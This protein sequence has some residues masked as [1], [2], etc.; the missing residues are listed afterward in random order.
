MNSLSKN[1]SAPGLKVGWLVASAEFVSAF[2][3]Y[4]ST[5]YGGPAS[6]FYTLVEVLGRMERWLL[7]GAQSLDRSHVAEFEKSYGLEL[8]TLQ[9][10]F[11]H[12]ALQREARTADLCDT[13]DAS[14]ALLRQGGV[15]TVE[16][17][18]SINVAIQL[19]PSATDYVA[20]RR[21]LRDERVSVFPG[22]LCLALSS[23]TVR[24]TA[25]KNWPELESGVRSVSEQLGRWVRGEYP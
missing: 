21:I 24:L 23:G 18:F 2:Y 13:R 8:D 14:V 20:F 17:R 9:K 11:D 4:S 19:P 25:A 10:A 15:K 12:Y 6:I 7:E 22:V 5:M 3:E 16:P 1:W